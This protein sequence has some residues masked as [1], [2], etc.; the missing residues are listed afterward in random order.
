V[1]ARGGVAFVRLDGQVL[2]HLAGFDLYY[3]WT[4][5]GAVILRTHGTYYV[6][7][8]ESHILERLASEKAA[9]LLVPQFQD[10]VDPIAESYLDLAR[11]SRAPDGSG[12]W[13]YALRSPDESMLL[14]QWTGE[15]EVP[16]AF[17]LS[18]TGSD[19]RPVI[20]G[21]EFIDIPN[22]RAMG[23]TPESQ[24]VVHVMD[25][26]CGLGHRAGVYLIDPAGGTELVVRVP[27]AGGAR[28]WGAE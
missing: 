18:A 27:S 12:F 11:P 4:V 13:A 23:W 15:C 7:H 25:G 24:A 3:E 17:L 2:D 20:G 14:G 22:T 8:P 28:M 10:A 9:S 1:D 16:M 19:P 6:L 5:P 21:P 26:A